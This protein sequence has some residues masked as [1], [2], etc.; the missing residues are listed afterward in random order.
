[1]KKSFQLTLFFLI[2]SGWS[3]F[4]QVPPP[5]PSNASSSNGPVGA[6][7]PIGGGTVILVLMGA[8]YGVKK[9]SSSHATKTIK[10]LKE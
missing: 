9:Y 6:S 2:L 7:S 5:P 10:K 8:A 4:A 3:L 1:M